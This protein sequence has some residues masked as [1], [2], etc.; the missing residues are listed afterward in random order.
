MECTVQVDARM[1][2]VALETYL[3]TTGLQ[4]QCAITPWIDYL[5][6]HIL[7]A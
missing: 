5:K 4:R 1:I 6:A 3:N 7:A 2:V